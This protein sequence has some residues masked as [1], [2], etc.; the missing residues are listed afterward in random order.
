MMCFGIGRKE[1]SMLNLK[2]KT[3]SQYRWVLDNFCYIIKPVLGTAYYVRAI[4]STYIT[5]YIFQYVLSLS[6]DSRYFF[7]LNDYSTLLSNE[8]LCIYK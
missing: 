3:V 1:I 5:I 7:V 2:I 6:C 8:L 4:K